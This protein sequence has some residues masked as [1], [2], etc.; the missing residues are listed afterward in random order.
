MNSMKAA[1]LLAALR[2]EGKVN[3]ASGQEKAV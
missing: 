2:C 3:L 1:K